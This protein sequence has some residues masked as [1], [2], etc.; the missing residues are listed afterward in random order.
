MV[1]I[2]VLIVLMILAFKDFY[3]MEAPPILRTLYRTAVEEEI[4]G[5]TLPPVNGDEDSELSIQCLLPMTISS[6]AKKSKGG[7]GSI[8]TDSPWT[9]STT[10]TSS[11]SPRREKRP[12]PSGS[13]ITTAM[14]CSRP[15][16][17]CK[18]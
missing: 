5:L 17:P 13:T 18:S 1:G 11:T 15:V 14:R 3:G 16:I 2:A 7:W 12:R 9:I 8:V 4:V 10:V 6:F